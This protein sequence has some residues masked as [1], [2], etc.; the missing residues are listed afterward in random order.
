MLPQTV[1]KPPQW[2]IEARRML[3]L[4]TLE[5]ETVERV[6]EQMRKARKEKKRNAG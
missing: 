1:K 4:G 3:A 6:I 2:E 5:P